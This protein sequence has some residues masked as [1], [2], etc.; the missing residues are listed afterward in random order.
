LPE[1]GDRIQ[2]PKRC[3]LKYK[4]MICSNEC[5]ATIFSF[6]AF[7]L[8]AHHP[9]LE[10]LTLLREL[11]CHLRRYYSDLWNSLQ[12]SN[13]EFYS[14]VTSRTLCAV[15]ATSTAPK[16]DMAYN[17]FYIHLITYNNRLIRQ[18]FPNLLF[19]LNCLIRK[20]TL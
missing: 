10:I 5:A 1:D 12:I 13:S 20:I 7:V 14:S 17:A 19:P 9:H 8:A 3:V 15:G 16:D 2:S 6:L 4:S 18:E 11:S